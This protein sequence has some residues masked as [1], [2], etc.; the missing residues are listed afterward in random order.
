M[1][2]YFKRCPNCDHI[3]NTRDELLSDNNVILKGYL[4]GFSEL[5]ASLIYF[6]H[7][8]HDCNSTFSLK[9][10]YFKDLIPETT[11]TSKVIIPETC[12]E[13]CLRKYDLTPCVHNCE[14]SYVRNVLEIIKHWNK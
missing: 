5:R 9:I 13:Y 1:N 6:D 3:W 12:P 8:E 7:N 14:C 4:L 11:F 2:P 10:E